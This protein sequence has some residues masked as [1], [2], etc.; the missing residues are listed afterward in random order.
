MQPETQEIEHLVVEPGEPAPDVAGEKVVPAP[1]QT[2][3]PVRELAGEGVVP[4]VERGRRLGE[5]QIQPPASIDA[6][7]R[8]EGGASGVESGRCRARCDQSSI[9]R[10]GEDGTATP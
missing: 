1:P 4:R 9:P 5:R 10:S 8:V 3:R 7:E 2:H 6:P